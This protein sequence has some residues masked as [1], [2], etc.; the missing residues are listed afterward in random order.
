MDDSVEIGLK[1]QLGSTL[2]VH[3]VGFKFEISNI[4]VSNCM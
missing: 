1:T 2:D 3:N 4:E